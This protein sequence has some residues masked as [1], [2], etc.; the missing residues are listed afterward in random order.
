[1]EAIVLS[2]EKSVPIVEHMVVK[3]A[4]LWPDHPFTFRIPDSVPGRD[5]SE[6]NPD[7]VSLIPVRD[8]QIRGTV[9]DLVLDLD[10][11][12]WVYWCIDDKYP[13]RINVSKMNRLVHEVRSL[14]NPTIAAVCPT[15]PRQDKWRSLDPATELRLGGRRYRDRGDWSRIWLHQFV[16][17]R[18]LRELMEPMPAKLAR[19]KMM[20]DLLKTRSPWQDSMTY[21]VRRSL[22]TVGE[23]TTRGRLT[24]NC[25]ESMQRCGV[26]APGY[27]V[28]DSVIIRGRSRWPRLPFKR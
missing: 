7:R 19:A 2:H 13:V 23:S 4:E 6:R 27:S 20:D 8:T 21:I 28:T 15:Q 17:V 18:L 11:E 14:D 10:P 24:K 16:R 25:A 1:M 26:L 12:T 5:L 3:Y 22:I 9:L